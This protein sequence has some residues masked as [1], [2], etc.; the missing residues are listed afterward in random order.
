MT[1]LISILRFYMAILAAK[2]KFAKEKFIIP[3]IIFASLICYGFASLILYLQN[4]FGYRNAISK[5]LNQGENI[6]SW[7]LVGILVSFWIGMNLI[8][9]ICD[10]LLYKFVKKQ[11]ANQNVSGSTLV[12]WKST[13]SNLTEDLQI[14]IRATGISTLLIFLSMTLVILFPVFLN[15]ESIAAKDFIGYAITFVVLFSANSPFFIVIFTIKRHK[16]VG[17]LGTFQQPPKQ[18]Q[19]HM[20]EN[21]ELETI[22]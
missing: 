20:D 18:L 11:D 10:I 4:I 13:N 8:G 19:F 17:Q 16:K 3:F 9:L 6:D 22:T 1:N 5:C 14:P 7:I 12:P 21:L 15:L 2:A